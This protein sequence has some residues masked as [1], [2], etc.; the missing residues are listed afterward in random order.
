MDTMHLILVINLGSTSTKFAVYKN[1]TPLFDHTVR[2]AT[3]EFDACAGILDQKDIRMLYILETLAAHQIRPEDLSAVVSRGG[4]V[5]P[6]DS[7]TYLINGTMVRDLASGTSA[8]H[9]SS[10]GGVIASELGRNHN[11]PAYV[12]DPVVTDEME[13]RARLTGIPGIERRSV[14]H[15]LNTK[16]IARLCAEDLGIA[17]EDGR[18]VVAHMGGGITVGAHRYGRVVD[19]NDALAGEGPFTPERCGAVPV[20]PLVEMC[21]SGQYTEEEVLALCHRHGGM[22]AYL[23]TNDMREVEKMIMQ[24]DDHAA[25]IMDSM[26]YQ[27]A[28]EIGAMVAV[29]EGRVNAIILT[30]GLAHSMRFTGAIKQMVD[31]IAPVKTYPGEHEMI[32]LVMGALRVLRGKEKAAMYA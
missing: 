20:E 5:T 3:G 24:G 31:Q 12:V 11:I 2:H 8:N 4:L 17:Y 10:L 7:G 23:D 29:L 25:L 14:F 19:V 16:A 30:G 22:V 1:E 13:P 15:A 28:K 6:L 27:V 18:F 9:T 26:A 21:F 32:A